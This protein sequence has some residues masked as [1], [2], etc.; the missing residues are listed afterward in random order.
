MRSGNGLSN[1]HIHG[2]LFA[3]LYGLLSS[4]MIELELDGR[5]CVLWLAWL[6]CE[7]ERCCDFILMLSVLFYLEIQIVRVFGRTSINC[8]N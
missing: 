4:H 8:A 3:G 7:K 5:M 2:F 1:T 6:H